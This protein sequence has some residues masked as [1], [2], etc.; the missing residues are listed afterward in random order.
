MTAKRTTP[1]T[2]DINGFA[3]RFIRVLSGVGVRELAEQIGKDRTYIA[4]IEAGRCRRVSPG[5]YND[6]LT[7]LHI[8]DRRVL[9]AS[10]HCDDSEAVA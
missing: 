2:V 1:T 9:L 8:E 10:P 4:H 7:A 6:I 3:L 5:A